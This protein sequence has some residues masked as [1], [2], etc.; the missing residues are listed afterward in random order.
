M[1]RD[2]K[3]DELPISL[4]EVID[5]ARFTQML[6]DELPEVPQA[7]DEY[8]R[9]LLHCEMGVFARLTDEAIGTGDH[10]RVARYFEFIDRVRRRASPEVQNAIDVS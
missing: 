9:G 7:F 5:H 4:P 6:I 3:Q 1:S 8:G 2:E 10:Q